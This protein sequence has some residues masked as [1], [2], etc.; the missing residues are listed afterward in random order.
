M[1][2]TRLVCYA[3][4]IAAAAPAAAQ[5]KFVA[6]SVEGSALAELCRVDRGLVLD[7]CTSFI[8]GAADGLSYGKAICPHQDGWSAVAVATVRKFIADN[9]QSLSWRAIHVVAEA[10]RAEYPCR[11]K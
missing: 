2:V 10:L 11:K 1:G 5:D 9:P 8:L 6:T 4:A 3:A 7:G